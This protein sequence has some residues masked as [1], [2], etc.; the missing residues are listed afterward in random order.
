MQNL[1]TGTVLAF[2]RK[3]LRKCPALQASNKEMLW[4]DTLQGMSEADLIDADSRDALNR[5]RTNMLRLVKETPLLLAVQF[6][7]AYQQLFAHRYVV[8][9]LEERVQGSQFIVT[10]AGEQWA[11]GEAPIPEDMPGYLG[12]LE[13]TVP[14]LYPLVSEYIQEA[15]STYQHHMY[16]SAAVMLGVAS[17]KVIYLLMDELRCALTDNGRKQRIDKVMG[18][19]A[20]LSDVFDRLFDNLDHARDNANLPSH[21]HEESLNHLRCFQDAIRAH[22]NEAV[23][24]NPGQVRP[25]SVRLT[26]AAFPSAC[27]K[28]EDLLGWLRENKI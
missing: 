15:L 9:H 1:D 11:R 16:F 20:N 2:M 27:K 4:D 3:A 26:L 17:E 23:H 6:Q 19:R 12:V 5:L 7:E 21:I 18:R 10:P 25:E 28:A 13:K 8:P 14:D 24:P 22:R